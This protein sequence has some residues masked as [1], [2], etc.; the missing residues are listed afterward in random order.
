MNGLKNKQKLRLYLFCL[1][2]GLRSHFDW[3]VF[4]FFVVVFVVVV[5]LPLHI[6]ILTVHNHF[7][8]LPKFYN[9]AKII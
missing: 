7:A 9:F 6:L 2:K 8:E 4:F 3:F 5:F 1:H